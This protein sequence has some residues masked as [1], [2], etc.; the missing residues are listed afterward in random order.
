MYVC[1]GGRETGKTES[2]ITLIHTG[3]Q[4]GPRWRALFGKSGP[5]IP[6][7]ALSFHAFVPFNFPLS[8]DYDR[9]NGSEARRDSP[10]R[11]ADRQPRSRIPRRGRTEGGESPVVVPRKT[12]LLS[13][14][15]SVSGVVSLSRFRRGNGDSGA[16]RVMENWKIWSD[17]P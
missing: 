7:F 17:W 4:T 16:I 5:K 12:N 2:Q 15:L 3:G 11:T 14:F 9:Q 13:S 1:A 10:S 8:S 6:V